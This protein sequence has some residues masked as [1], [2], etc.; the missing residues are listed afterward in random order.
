MFLAQIHGRPR[1]QNQL[2]DTFDKIFF[3]IYQK[4]HTFWLGFLKN[5]YVLS[6]FPIR[7]GGVSLR[8]GILRKSTEG[9]SAHGILRNSTIGFSAHGILKIP[10]VELLRIP[11]ADSPVV[12]FLRIPCA[13]SPLLDVL[14]RGRRWS[15]SRTCIIHAWIS[16]VLMFGRHRCV[17]VLSH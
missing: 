11:C 6:S 8:T 3:L 2:F 14:W 4:T 15:T 12:E 17:L 9:V 13:I 16:A 7:D 1:G 5:L 10:L